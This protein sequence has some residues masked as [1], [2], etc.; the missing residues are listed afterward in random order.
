M[1]FNFKKHWDLYLVFL[2]LIIRLLINIEF[3]LLS[4]FFFFIYLF[5]LIILI[6][7]KKNFSLLFILFL[8]LDNMI[9][10]YLATIHNS[11]NF[12]YYGTMIINF[13]IM[14][15]IIKNIHKDFKN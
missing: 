9:G 8:A 14:T 10:T 7:R 4:L 15:I 2:F 12:M 13:V 5:F 1:K 11:F 3:S 6:L